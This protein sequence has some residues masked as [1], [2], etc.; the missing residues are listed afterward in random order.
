[1][2]RK[3]IVPT[4]GPFRILAIYLL[5]AAWVTGCR[6]EAGAS[7]ARKFRG[8][9]SLVIVIGPSQTHPQWPGIRGG[10]EKA[11]SEIPYAR[12]DFI[13]PPTGTERDL[14]R[15]VVASIAREPFAICLYVVDDATAR[16]AAKKI[17]DQ[18]ILLVTMGAELSELQVYAAV[19]INY[20]AAAEKLGRILLKA[21]DG[22]RSYLL[23]H[24][25]GRDPVATDCYNRFR[26]QAANQYSLSLL[27][28]RNAADSPLAPAA[29]IREMTTTFRHAGLMVTL[30]P[31]PWFTHRPRDLLGANT[32][33]ATLAATPNLWPS[34]QNGTAAAL[35]GPLD[36][37]VGSTAIDMITDALTGADARSAPRLIECEV[38][39]PEDLAAFARRYADAAGLELSTLL[40]RKAATQPSSGPG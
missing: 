39:L 35:V 25:S 19:R 30:D 16:P 14:T 17:V 37:V 32:R 20:P 33:F 11:A 3:L 21:A 15:L 18:G 9:G 5:L 40:P 26:A 10:A 13:A 31:A 1:M 29:L 4:G 7:A 12:F 34:L 23:L 28:Q 36:G 8:G 24:E 27:E 22:K 6:D 2:L 38:V